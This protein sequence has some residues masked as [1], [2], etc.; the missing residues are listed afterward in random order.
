MSLTTFLQSLNENTE[1][2]VYAVLCPLFK[3]SRKWEFQ[4]FGPLLVC[5]FIFYDKML[6]RERPKCKSY[7]NGVKFREILENESWDLK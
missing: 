1:K 2:E 3:L 5:V 6:G 4:R 7:F